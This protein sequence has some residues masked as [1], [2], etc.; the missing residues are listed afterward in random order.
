MQNG[1]WFLRYNIC[2][3]FGG[4]IRGTWEQKEVSLIAV[5]QKSAMQEAD[6][7]WNELVKIARSE[8]EKKKTGLILRKIHLSMVPLNP[9]LFIKLT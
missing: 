4:G 1:K 9:V 2:D 6:S 7:K 5:N 3:T 8:F